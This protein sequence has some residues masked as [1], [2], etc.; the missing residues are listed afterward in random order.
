MLKITAGIMHV[1][2]NY[3]SQVKHNNFF[4]NILHLWHP[5]FIFNILHI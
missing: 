4:T 5:N 1:C 2:A 3:Y